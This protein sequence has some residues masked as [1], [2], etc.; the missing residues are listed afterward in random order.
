MHYRLQIPYGLRLKAGSTKTRI[1]TKKP[2][3]VEL[4]AQQ[5]LKAGSTK[6]RIETFLV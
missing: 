5:C 2:L 3:H 1:E 4:M 6:T